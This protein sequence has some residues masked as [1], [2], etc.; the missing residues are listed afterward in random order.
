MSAPRLLL[1]VVL[2]LGSCTSTKKNVVVAPSTGPKD[3][4][5]SEEATTSRSDTWTLSG[6]AQGA[7]LLG[8]M[9][10]VHRS[11]SHREPEA[12]ALFDQG[13]ALTY[14]FNHDEAARSF[15]RAAEIDPSCA[16][17]FWGIAY[18]LGPNYNMPVLKE[19][20][21][22]SWDALKQA[23][24]VAG[25]NASAVEQALIAALA[26]R[27][28]GPKWID[29]VSM[30]RYNEAYAGAMR[31][32][33]AQYPTDFDVQTLYA[34][35]L[36]NLNPW[37]LWTNTGE[38]GEHTEEIVQRLEHVLAN[39]PDH[40]GANHLYIHAVEASKAPERALP[41]ATKL[42]GLVPGAGHI[43]HM[44][45]HIYQRV[46]RYADA[47]DANRRAIVTDTAYLEQV[48]PIGYYPFYLAHNYGFLAFA[49]SMQGRSQEALEAA[50]FSAENIP[51]DMVCGMPGMDFFLSAPLF[52]MVRFG[53]WDDI[54]SAPKPD[55]K[56]AVLLGLW[57]HAQG[58]ARAS[59]GDPSAAL[60]H[61]ET[62][63]QIE[64]SLPSELMADQNEAQQVLLVA[65]KV[66]E[67]RAA[68]A[69]KQPGA[70]ALWREAVALEDELTYAEPDDWFYPL[71]HYLGAAL[72]D[73]GQAGEAEAVYRKDL[74]EHPHNGWA[75]F[76]L[77][78]ALTQQK[79]AKQA[80]EAHR[81]YEVAFQD[82]DVKLTRS[83]F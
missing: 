60:E 82:S 53:R 35:S 29:P 5:N 70:L 18:A 20:A 64:R 47:A 56:H 58:M 77:S 31:E 48:T 32:V 1:V 4:E 51:V 68:E 41:S 63:R 34:E 8:N 15:A 81:A 75:L 26:K 50:R 62:I 36:M 37:H 44:P 73:A 67:A 45:A 46:G 12:Q 57:H 40:A 66:V 14:G 55:A 59:K 17:C 69:A 3:S 25:A 76:G 52:V 7:K 13:L 61:A 74:E 80:A 22:V 78:R 10:Q 72:V 42:A 43:V 19:R 16:L 11:V 38:P 71:R 6:L 83:A 9:G 21:R 39:E 49:A 28:D 24:R 27:Y 54:L 30:Q 65:A 23:E 2:L 79:K 33:A